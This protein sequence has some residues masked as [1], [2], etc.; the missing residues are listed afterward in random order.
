MATIRRRPLNALDNLAEERLRRLQNL[1]PEIERAQEVLRQF[2][3]VP[4]LIERSAR[5]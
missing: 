1:L 4:P 2:A 3:S 5:A